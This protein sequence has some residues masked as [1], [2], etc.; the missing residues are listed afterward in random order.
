MNKSLSRIYPLGIFLLSLAV[1]A[2]AFFKA[3]FKNGLKNFYTWDAGW[4]ASIVDRGYVFDGNYGHQANIAFFPFYPWTARAVKFATGGIPTYQAMYLTS[5]IM[6]IIASMLF[7]RM[8]RNRYGIRAASL[9]LVFMLLGPFSFYFY[10][11]HT[12]SMQLCMVLLFF[13]LL[14]DKQ[15]YFAAACVAGIASGV[16]LTGNALGLVYAA[17]VLSDYYRIYGL[18]L[19][20]KTREFARILYGPLCGVGLMVYMSHLYLHFGDPLAFTKII[21]AWYGSVPLQAGMDWQRFLSLEN[22]FREL[23]QAFPKPRALLQWEL[24]CVWVATLQFLLFPLLLIGA[25]KVLDWSFL[26]YFGCYF[27]FIYAA[28]YAYPLGMASIGRYLLMCFPAW[29][30]A[31]VLLSAGITAAQQRVKKWPAL[32]SSGYFLFFILIFGSLCYRYAANYFKGIWVS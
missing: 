15:N 26:L 2:Y 25:R 29:M 6:I 16:K 9:G 32:V 21:Q 22:P 8:A 10:T 5:L 4:Y 31:G 12:E 28:T 11:G 18:R 27:F 1:F 20:I 7:Y 24:H 13:Y 17:V 14:R 3:F 23:L 19:Q 30:A